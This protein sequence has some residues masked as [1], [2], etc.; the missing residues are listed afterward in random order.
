MEEEEE[1]E[2]EEERD[3]KMDEEDEKDNEEKEKAKKKS[4]RRKQI[5]FGAGVFP[6]TGEERQRSDDSRPPEDSSR[7]LSME[8]AREN[9]LSEPQGNS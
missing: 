4:K 9:A 7:V 8:N 1:E 3:T 5:S 2:E 6:P